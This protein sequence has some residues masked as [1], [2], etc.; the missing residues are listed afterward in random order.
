MGEDDASVVGDTFSEGRSNKRWRDAP[1]SFRR[2]RSRWI[3]RLE[4]R[5]QGI[6]CRTRRSE[7]MLLPWRRSCEVMCVRCEPRDGRLLPA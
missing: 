5:A 3:S 7:E 2:D 1:S 4:G 6:D